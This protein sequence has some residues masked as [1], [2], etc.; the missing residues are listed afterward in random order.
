MIPRQ[1][2]AEA[3]AGPDVG[4]VEALS[5]PFFEDVHR[6]FAAAL[7][8]WTEATLPS[9]PHD[10]VDAACRAREIGRAHV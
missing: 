1:H 3:T 10:D 7:S 4:L 9:L 6:D 5:W 2:R 8:R